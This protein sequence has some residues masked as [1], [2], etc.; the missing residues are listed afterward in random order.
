MLKEDHAVT[1]YISGLSP[2]TP[3]EAYLIGK[4]WGD[5]AI[6][7]RVTEFFARHVNCSEAGQGVV[8]YLEC[9]GSDQQLLAYGEAPLKYAAGS[10]DTNAAY[11]ALGALYRERGDVAAA[12]S[13]FGEATR[14]FGN[15]RRAYYDIGTMLL[16]KGRRR[17]A[18]TYLE[19]AVRVAPDFTSARRDL[20]V[21]TRSV[22]P[23]D[24]ATQLAEMFR[25]RPTLDPAAAAPDADGAL[26]LGINDWSYVITRIGEIF[27]AVP[28]ALGTI[29]ARTLKR[30]ADR[31]VRR[32]LLVTAMDDGDLTDQDSA[33]AAAIGKSGP[34]FR[35]SWRLKAGLAKR[36]LRHL[37]QRLARSRDFA[38][39]VVRP[40]VRSLDGRWE[41]YKLK[42]KIF[43]SNDFWL[44]VREIELRSE[45]IQCVMQ[46]YGG[47][48]IVRWR[49]DAFGVPGD[50]QPFSAFDLASARHLRE[51]KSG[52]S[53]ILFASTV[54]ELKRMIDSRIQT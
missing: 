50:L 34:S 21:L 43:A 17:A 6:M 1:R 10:T 22:S 9:L 25:Y 54:G 41:R 4:L 15:I 30:G 5:L 3:Y 27:Y 13:A 49:Y 52:R 8:V 46:D 33:T 31:F 7:K 16:E 53:G 51:N 47:Y 37:A 35:D 38:P 14:R 44:V 23:R 19:R 36:R 32:C 11:L 18:I 20:A 39:E 24:S 2:N 40:V 12:I 42:R 48:R 29:P 28:R 45:P 26:T